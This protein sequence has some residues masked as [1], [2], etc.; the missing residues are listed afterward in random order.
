[1]DNLTAGLEGCAAYLDDPIVIGR[2]RE[3]HDRNVF[4]VFKRLEEYGFRV[5]IEMCSFIKEKKQAY[6]QF[7]K[8]ESKTADPKKIVAITKMPAPTNREGLQ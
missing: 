6:G 5:R 1:M 2:S 7:A 3:E 8:R 4:V